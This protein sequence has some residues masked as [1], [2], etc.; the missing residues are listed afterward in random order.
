MYKHTIKGIFKKN[1]ELK[2]KRFNI[3]QFKNVIQF[4]ITFY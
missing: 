2:L 1:A 4:L 3:V